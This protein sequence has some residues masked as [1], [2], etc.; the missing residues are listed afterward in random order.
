MRTT[1]TPIKSH[2]APS[3]LHQ[4]ADEASSSANNVFDKSDSNLE[5]QTEQLRNLKSE[6]MELVRL[7]DRAFDAL[8]SDQLEIF[9]SR[10]LLAKSILK[11]SEVISKETMTRSLKQLTDRLQ[12]NFESAQKIRELKLRNETIA[13]DRKSAIG[14]SMQDQNKSYE[15]ADKPMKTD[16]NVP[17]HLLSE[18]NDLREWLCN[19]RQL[20]G[21]F[22]DVIEDGTPTAAKIYKNII[23]EQKPSLDEQIS[24]LKEPVMGKTQR[25]DTHTGAFHGLQDLKDQMHRSLKTEEK[26]APSKEKTVFTANAIEKS[27][28]WNSSERYLFEKFIESTKMIELSNS[29]LSAYA[30][31]LL[32]S[33]VLSQG[34]PENDTCKTY[35]YLSSIIFESLKRSIT[36]I[37]TALKSR[38]NRLSISALSDDLFINSL[39][40]TAKVIQGHFAIQRQLFMANSVSEKIIASQSPTAVIENILKIRAKTEQITSDVKG[41]LMIDR[42]FKDFGI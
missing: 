21:L 16:L 19:G 1:T 39:H 14:D 4:T 38:I 33:T 11:K 15:S 25:D 20:A 41:L 42:L 10:D 35:W 36:G 34:E 26:R 3:K 40:L 8:A 30:I 13:D 31:L 7:V 27:L 17:I 5:I 28:R 29:N 22:H 24:Q 23:E 18:N 32:Q 2:L 6:K 37:D 9:R 12:K